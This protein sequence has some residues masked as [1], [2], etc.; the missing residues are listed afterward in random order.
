VN[1]ARGLVTATV[2]VAFDVW[3][4]AHVTNRRFARF[5]ERTDASS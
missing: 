2:L 3:Q 4:A 1:V 5:G